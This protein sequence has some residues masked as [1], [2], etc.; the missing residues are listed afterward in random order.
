MASAKLKSDPLTHDDA[1]AV[2]GAATVRRL[3]LTPA[4]AGRDVSLEEFENANLKEGWRYELIDGRIEVFPNPELPHDMV[5]VWIN[6]RLV[7]YSEAHKGVIRY[8]SPG[9]RVFIPGRR[10][11]TCP[12]PDLAAYRDSPSRWSRELRHWQAMQPLLVVEVLS[13]KY[14]KKDLVRNVG[15]YKEA[16]S[17]KEYWVLN[18]R[19][20]GDHPTLR[21]Y[22]KRGD[23]SWQKPI[24]VPFGGTYTT[25]L[26]PG[27]T[28]IVD[29][30]V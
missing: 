24:D 20:G 10:E 29:P 13:E 6:R 5:V 17:V 28:L 3:R 12:Q 11:A 25:P 19:D 23:R 2:N 9:S 26:L 30:S 27:F 4:W 15:L 1:A 16:P 7:L 14:H 8:V 18:P 22:R 21:V